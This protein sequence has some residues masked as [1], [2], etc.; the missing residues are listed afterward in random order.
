MAFDTSVVP[1][2]V[3]LE[4]LY[5]DAEPV[6]VLPSMA[7]NIIQVLVPDDHV[8]PQGFH[9]ILL[10]N[11][12]TEIV[13]AT[14]SRDMSGLRTLLSVMSKLQADLESQRRECR[15]RFS[16]LQSGPYPNCGRVVVS[17]MTCHAMAYH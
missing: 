6:R 15:R 2:V 4:A 11:M 7:E 3:G 17:S 12:T 1:N 5:A 10:D 9:D 14:S 16:V 13:P 8:E